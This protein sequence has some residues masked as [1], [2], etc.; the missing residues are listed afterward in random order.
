MPSAYKSGILDFFQVAGAPGVYN[1]A[2]GSGFG[3][4][5]GKKTGLVAGVN[6]VAQNGSDS[7]TGE[8]DASGALNTL[9]QIG[10]RGQNW[11]AAFGTHVIVDQKA[12]GEGTSR[13]AGGWGI[14]AHL[15]KSFVKAGQEV[16]KGDK[17]GLSGN[18]G[19]SSGP[20]LHYEIRDNERYSAGKD[21]DPMPF[22]NLK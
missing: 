2:V 22:I 20:H 14:Y 7:S 11:G 4:Q 3:I 10:Y 17:I 15:S 16:K 5:Y 19:N 6:Y 1:K 12:I 9:A 18:T 13:I 21:K 8:F